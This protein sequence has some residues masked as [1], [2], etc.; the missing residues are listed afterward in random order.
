MV[1]NKI[2]SI[3]IFLEMVLNKITKFGVFFKWFRVRIVQNKITK[4]QVF[5]FFFSSIKWFRTEFR[6][7][8][9]SAKLAWN[10]ILSVFLSSKQTE[11]QW[12]ESK[13][14]SVPWN[15][16]FWKNGNPSPESDRKEGGILGTD[17]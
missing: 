11:F 17:I 7:F 2:L 14:P 15:I 8:L 6:A 1:Q 4:Y 9:S 12:K 5:L 16:F 10:G 13:Y 3:F